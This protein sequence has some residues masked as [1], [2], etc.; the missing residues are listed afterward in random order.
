MSWY[1]AILFITSLRVQRS[2]QERMGTQRGTTRI[3]LLT[4]K[5]GG[6]GECV[7]YYLGNSGGRKFFR[8]NSPISRGPQLRGYQEKLENSRRETSIIHE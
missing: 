8:E 3:T 7:H 2:T 1:Y 6:R 4:R 5:I